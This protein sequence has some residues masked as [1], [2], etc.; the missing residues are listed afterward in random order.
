[1]KNSLEADV[2]NDSRDSVSVS[3]SKL[4]SICVSD[5]SVCGA[6]TG[7]NN[8]SRDSVSVSIFITTA[9][10][11]PKIPKTVARTP[12]EIKITKIAIRMI[13]GVKTY[14]LI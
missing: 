7:G 13:F 6:V 11:L 4:S 5:D 14:L 10:L 9:S 1:M 3:I 8:D 2:N 12:N